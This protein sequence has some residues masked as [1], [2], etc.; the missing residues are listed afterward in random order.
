MNAG[1]ELDALVAE[2]VYGA[3]VDGERSSIDPDA[4]LWITTPHFS[5][6]ILDAW[7]LLEHMEKQGYKWWGEGGQRTASAYFYLPNHKRGYSVM[8][9]A[10]TTPAAI[11]LAAMDA[12]NRKTP[13][14]VEGPFG[15]A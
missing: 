7:C 11:C 12:M 1:R 5:T 9:E 6:S 10:A 15:I 2:K 8:S 4:D 13:I 3:V 14:V